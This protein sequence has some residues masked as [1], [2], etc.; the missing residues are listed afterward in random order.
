MLKEMFLVGAG[1]SKAVKAEM[2]L[3]GELTKALH[4]DTIGEKYKFIGNVEE[5]LSYLGQSHPWED[6][7]CFYHDELGTIFLTINR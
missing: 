2:P 6:I 5:V 4:S 7:R 3:M 1:F